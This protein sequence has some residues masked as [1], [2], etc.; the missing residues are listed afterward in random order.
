MVGHFA[1][2]MDFLGVLKDDGYFTGYFIDLLQFCFV[3]LIQVRIV[4][5]R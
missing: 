4:W 3:K 1:K 2:R 5:K